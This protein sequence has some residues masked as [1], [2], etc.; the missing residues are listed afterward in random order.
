MLTKIILKGNLG[1]KFGEEFNASV[2]NP[3]EVKK[4]TDLQLHNKIKELKIYNPATVYLMQSK[5]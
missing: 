5:Y 2:E 3:K 4:R 1:E